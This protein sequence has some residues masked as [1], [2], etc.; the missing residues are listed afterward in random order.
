[1][2]TNT[3]RVNQKSYHTT[4]QPKKP[5]RPPGAGALVESR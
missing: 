5:C 4:P 1:M 2:K 3:T